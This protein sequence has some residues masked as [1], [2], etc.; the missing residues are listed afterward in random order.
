MVSVAYSH[1]CVT[2][3]ADKR[4]PASFAVVEKAASGFIV[5]SFFEQTAT[6]VNPYTIS[7]LGNKAY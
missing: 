7:A 1:G 4:Q 5:L 6:G 2:R 3:T